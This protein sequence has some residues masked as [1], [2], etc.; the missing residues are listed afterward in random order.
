VAARVTFD[1]SAGMRAVYPSGASASCTG[2]TI[3]STPACFRGTVKQE[4]RL[5][6]RRQCLTAC[7][8]AL[9]GRFDEE[10]LIIESQ[11][12]G[13]LGD[14]DVDRRAGEDGGD[15]ELELASERKPG[16]RPAGAFSTV[17]SA[18]VR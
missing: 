12:S 4:G 2:T 10:G 1:T 14:V 5:P 17:A 9:V 13:L 15:Y 8:P 7:D 6:I 16:R 18:L 11:A 3:T